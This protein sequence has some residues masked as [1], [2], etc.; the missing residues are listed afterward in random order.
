MDLALGMRNKSRWHASSRS[1]LFYFLRDAEN[2]IRFL[3]LTETVTG[4][5]TAAEIA[6]GTLYFDITAVWIT[7]IGVECGFCQVECLTTRRRHKA[8]QVVFVD[9][10]SYYNVKNMDK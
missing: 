5:I 8:G 9:T 4:S 3:K 1:K 7:T 10:K 6:A 2:R